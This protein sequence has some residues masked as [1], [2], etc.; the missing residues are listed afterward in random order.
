MAALGAHAAAPATVP[1]TTLI[2]AMQETRQ[3]FPV[4]DDEPP[5]TE[6]D[7]DAS[8]VA[9]M[10]SLA[11]ITRFRQFVNVHKRQ[12]QL[13]ST[14]HEADA[15]DGGAGS[16]WEELC[17]ASRCAGALRDTCSAECE[18]ARWKHTITTQQRVPATIQRKIHRHL[19]RGAS[20][21]DEDTWTFLP[22]CRARGKLVVCVSRGDTREWVKKEL[23]YDQV[24]ST[25]HRS[26]PRTDFIVH[27][28]D[29]FTDKA[30]GDFELRIYRWME[31]RWDDG[32]HIPLANDGDSSMKGTAQLTSNTTIVATI[33]RVGEGLWLQMSENVDASAAAIAVLRQTRVLLPAPALAPAHHTRPAAAPS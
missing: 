20:T 21:N 2:R 19:N 23:P 1:L 13:C 9:Q 26:L 29:N 32:F 10:P 27:N 14:C 24:Y 8:A 18:L 5:C 30:P 22:A 28:L 16:F 31:R 17:F 4:N 7:F 3:L 11:K 33:H 12:P 25:T 6:C 15:S